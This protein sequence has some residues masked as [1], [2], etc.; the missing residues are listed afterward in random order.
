LAIEFSPGSLTVLGL[1]RSHWHCQLANFTWDEVKPSAFQARVHQFMEEVRAGES[2]HLLLTGKPG[3]G[4]SHV[5]VGLYRWAA[6]EFGTQLAAWLHVPSFCLR[7]KEGYGQGTEGDPWEMI[8]SAQRLI[9]L[10][11][12]FGREYSPH[13]IGHIV[14]SLIDGCYRSAAGV[15][16]TMNSSIAELTQRLSP[17][18]RSRLLT[19]ATIIP[20]EAARDHRIKVLS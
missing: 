5:S 15:V 4:K 17:H 10:D 6:L 14:A 19:N 3:V 7:V 9:V 1:P 12:L 13:E 8:E 16:V 11:D 2:P 20:V 18:E